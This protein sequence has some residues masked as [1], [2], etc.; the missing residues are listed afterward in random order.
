[1]DVTS[2]EEK[3]IYDPSMHCSKRAADAFYEWKRIDK[4]TKQPYAFGM[5][6]DAPFAFAG[7][8]ERW[9]APDNKPVDTFAIITTDPNELAATVHNRMPVILEPPD[10]TRWLTRADEEQPP[11]DRRSRLCH[12]WRLHSR[13]YTLAQPSAL[14]FPHT[15]VRKSL[16]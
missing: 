13:V 15:F 9:I 4:T 14:R 2:I 12:Q 10:Y 16:S 7:V 6:D 11:I 3:S 5:K 1:M 8:W